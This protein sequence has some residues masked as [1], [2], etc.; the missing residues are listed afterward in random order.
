MSNTDSKT[1]PPRIQWHARS[2]AVTLGIMLLMPTVIQAEV[3]EGK[4]TYAGIALFAMAVSCIN[5]G[6]SIVGI[7]RY[8][9]GAP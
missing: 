6:N 1:T 3:A 9:K 8:L 2:G 7:A 5:L 4:S